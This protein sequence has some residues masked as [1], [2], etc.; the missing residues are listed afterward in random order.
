M[1]RSTST[2]GSDR[3]QQEM[4]LLKDELSSLHKVTAERTSN[5]EESVVGLEEYHAEYAEFIQWLG[6]VEVK[7]K[8]NA[9][10]FDLQAPEQLEM[11]LE[12]C[13]VVSLSLFSV[14]CSF[15]DLDLTDI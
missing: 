5:L 2:T 11:D 13:T 6:E 10:Q 8:V 1:L 7:V 4:K 14:F 9:Q 3:I 15:Y 12:V